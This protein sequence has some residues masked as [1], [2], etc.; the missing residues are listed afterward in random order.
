MVALSNPRT[1]SALVSLAAVWAK[2]HDGRVLAIHIVQVPDQTALSAAAKNRE[3]ID[4][5]SAD[6]LAAAEADAEA[7]GVPIET[8]AVLAERPTS[9]SL[10]ERLF[11]RR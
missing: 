7:V 10:R 2:H 5:E 4:A 1:E 3:R 6:L 11:R 9:R 8:P